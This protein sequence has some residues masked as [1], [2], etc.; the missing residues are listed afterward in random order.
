MKLL[1]V[2]VECP[3]MLEIKSL[4]VRDNRVFSDSFTIYF[5]TMA[6]KFWMVLMI[7]VF[8]KLRLKWFYCGSGSLRIK[9]FYF[10]SS[11]WLW[12]SEWNRRLRQWWGCQWYWHQKR[13]LKTQWFRWLLSVW[14]RSDIERMKKYAERRLKPEVM[15]LLAV[16]MLGW[17]T[18]AKRRL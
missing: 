12:C 18:N 15:A 5:C 1:T 16:V 11:H 9:Q 3:V 2:A 17:E 8:P 6:I 10:V 7:F 13:F 4:F 14:R